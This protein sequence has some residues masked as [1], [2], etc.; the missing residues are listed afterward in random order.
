MKDFIYP[1]VGETLTQ[2][3]V[4]NSIALYARDNYDQNETL[5]EIF[6]KEGCGAVFAAVFYDASVV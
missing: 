3:I 5:Q 6:D 4:F 1:P 2:R